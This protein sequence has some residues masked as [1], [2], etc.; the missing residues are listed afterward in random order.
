LQQGK[1]LLQLRCEDQR[2]RQSLRQLQALCHLLQGKPLKENDK[3]F[4]KGK[5]GFLAF[6]IASCL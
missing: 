1:R 3:I 2:L 6:P 5:T 4:T